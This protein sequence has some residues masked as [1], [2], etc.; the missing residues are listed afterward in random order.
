MKPA[1][2]NKAAVPAQP[3]IDPKVSKGTASPGPTPGQAG[4]HSS[5]AFKD[6]GMPD[7]KK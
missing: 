7:N 4:D 5:P 2:A 6:G 3:P 1:D